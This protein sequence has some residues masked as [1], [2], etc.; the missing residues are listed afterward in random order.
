LIGRLCF[1]RRRTRCAASCDA[2]L[3][4]AHAAQ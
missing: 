4:F 2:L 3:C 1:H